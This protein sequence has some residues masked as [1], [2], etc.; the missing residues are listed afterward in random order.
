MEK[1]NHLSP[2]PPWFYF[3]HEC[4]RKHKRMQ[5]EVHYLSFLF[6]FPCNESARVR[7]FSFF[8]LEFVMKAPC[9]GSVFQISIL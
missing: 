5:D 4:E 2:H 8:M 7:F 6:V 9:G 1:N 3:S